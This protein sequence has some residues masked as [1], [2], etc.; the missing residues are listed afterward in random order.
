MILFVTIISAALGH[1]L[2]VRNNCGYTIWP[3]II[4]NQ[5]TPLGKF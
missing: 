2:N 5:G 3:G 4:G 1:N